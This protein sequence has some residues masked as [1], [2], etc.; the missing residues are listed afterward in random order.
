[1]FRHVV[2]FRVRDGVESADVSDATM[3][4]RELGTHRLV[5]S[6]TVATSLDQRKGTIIVEDGTFA[7][8]ADFHEWRASDAHREAVDLMA[9]ISDWWIADWEEP[10]R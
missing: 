8:S 5:V 6:W 7:D 2:L 1:M 10:T 4:L 9:R 3:S